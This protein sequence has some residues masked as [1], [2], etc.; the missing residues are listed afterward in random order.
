M[1]RSKAPSPVKD[2]E[3]EVLELKEKIV[4]ISEESEGKSK[5]MEELKRRMGEIEE[6]K[7]LQKKLIE[8]AETERD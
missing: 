7:E 2:N 3:F 1:P 8:E 5:V 4:K 6:E